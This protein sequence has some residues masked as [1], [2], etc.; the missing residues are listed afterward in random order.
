MARVASIKST[1]MVLVDVKAFCRVIGEQLP[2][3]LAGF[4]VRIIISGVTAF[5]VEAAEMAVPAVLFPLV[6]EGVSLAK[7][8]S[9]GL[10]EKGAPRTQ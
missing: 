10:T 4:V 1:S 3:H 5:L 2:A 6:D 9:A 7:C 8:F